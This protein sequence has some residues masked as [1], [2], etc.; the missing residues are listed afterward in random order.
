MPEV[1]PLRPGDPD[2][3]GDHRLLGVLGS[4]GQGV[5][6]KGVDGAGR[7]VAIKLL[8][9]HLTQDDDVTRGLLREAEAARRVAAFCTAAVLDVGVADGRP[10]IVSEYVAGDTLQRLVRESGPRTGGALD[11]LAI[12]TLTALAAIHEAGIVHRDFKPGNVLMGPEGPIVIDFGIAKALGA[13]TQASAPMGTP[14]YMSPEQFAGERVGPASDVFSWAGTMVFAATGRPPYA[15]ETVAAILHKVMSGAPDLTGVPARLVEPIRSCLAKDPAARPTPAGLL[16]HLIS[17]PGSPDPTPL[18]SPPPPP[19]SASAPGVPDAA[20]LRPQHPAHPGVDGGPDRREGTPA[21]PPPPGAPI[22]SRGPGATAPPAGAGAGATAPPRGPGATVP[23]AGAGAGGT[24]H[25]SGAG[26]TVPPR[27]PG[28][29][30][31]PSGAGATGPAFHGEATRPGTDRRVS[32]RAVVVGGATAAVAA[33]AS[34]FLLLRPANGLADDPSPRPTGDPTGAPATG[35]PTAPVTPTTAAT[36]PA[37]STSPT[38]SPTASTTASPAAE[39]FGAPVREPVALPAGSGTPAVLAAAGSTVV[40]GTSKGTVLVWDLDPASAPVR[41]LGDGGAAATAVACG[42]GK[43]AT[44]HGDGAM[45][46]WNPAG[47][48]LRTKKAA[49]PVIAVTTAGRAVAVT[50]KYDSLK[51]LHSVVRLWDLATGRQIGPAVTDHFQGV[52]GL[53]FGRLGDDEVLVTGDGANRVRVRR[54]SDGKVTHTYKTGEIGGIELLA[55]G[56]LDGRPVLVSTHLD[57]TLRVYDL[58]TGRRRK[59]WDFSRRSPD[60]RGASALVVGALGGRPVA[61]VA[62]T[63][64]GGETV[65]RVWSLTDGK[66]VGELGPG[67]GAE[68]RALALAELEGRPVVVGTG[69]DAL[70]S[71]WSLGSA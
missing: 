34:A 53:A 7:E 47:G 49:D 8:H 26:A 52:N 43:A 40:C 42:D 31:P 16:R 58:A 55:C 46:L 61:V 48:A 14:A 70:L 32:R 12:S 15:G 60:D 11:R 41:R 50:Q 28:A 59:K 44:G 3:I 1:R 22:P 51:D 4:G 36:S 63:P 2:R 68:V 24:A 13:T 69:G 64:G 17:A 27:G 62:H 67:P 37:P 19:Y 33:A 18:P 30:V 10:Y 57:A 38:G 71:A 66:V 54:L 39:P 29:T 45:R 23:P 5:V 20:H 6:Y 56:E 65:V 21:T 9:S 25:P 35:T